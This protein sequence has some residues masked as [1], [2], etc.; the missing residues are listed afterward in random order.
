MAYVSL[1]RKWRP[2]NFGEVIGQEYVTRILGN[3]L[4]NG[5]Y[6]HAYLFA[7]P[8]GTGKTSTA[9]ILAKALNCEEGPTPDPCNRCTACRDITAGTSIDVVEIDAASNR[10]IN[11]IRD[12]RERVI[13]SPA[14]ARIKVYILDEA[15]MLTPEAF[16]ALLKMLEEPPVHVVFVLATTEP[17]R[18]P[19]T[20][21]SRCQRLDFRSVPA[22]LLAAHLARVCEEEGASASEGA[23]RLIARRARGSARD[24]LV[25]LEQAISYGDGTVEESEVASFL[26]MVE[27]EM[28]A[29]L[30]DCLIAGDAAGA[31]AMVERAYEQGRD[32]VQFAR[33]VQEH[34]RR[35]FLL[36]H[37]RLG[38]EDLEVDEDAH[39]RL[40]EQA[41]ELPPQPYPPLHRLPEGGGQG[42]AG[43]AVRP[44]GPGGSAH[45]H[46]PQRAGHLSRGPLGAPGQAG[47]RGRE[48]DAQRSCR[49]A[50]AG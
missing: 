15:H 12:L 50:R 29:Q 47:E 36:Q 41:R 7:G 21:L 17:H 38:P 32:L 16:N 35:V 25:V 6:S 22:S 2:Q 11:D 30:G 34:F 3:S 8:R 48:V 45:R 42:D 5:S 28:L 18:M 1:Y 44:A 26:G 24:A 19:P 33:E 37:A 14:A 13:F 31:I 39:G 9:R 23:L 10:G 40:Q 43:F 46:G 20:I 27:D 4:R 49:G